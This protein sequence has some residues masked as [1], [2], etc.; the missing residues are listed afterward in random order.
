MIL[1]TQIKLL[2]S[3]NSK[4]SGA[5]WRPLELLVMR[6]FYMINDEEIDYRK[7]YSVSEEHVCSCY[8]EH[9]NNGLHGRCWCNPITEHYEH[10]DVIIHN[11]TQ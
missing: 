7:V 11:E 1:V 8:L 5:P 3:A 10:G 2:L 9:C 6:G 4:V